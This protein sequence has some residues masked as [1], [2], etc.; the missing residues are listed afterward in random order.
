MVEPI[1]LDL[2]FELLDQNPRLIFGVLKNL[3]ISYQHP[4]YD[5]SL[6]VA[7]E[8]FVKSALRYQKPLEKAAQDPQFGSYA[9]TTVRFAVLR[10]LKK[11][12]RHSETQLNMLDD[13]NEE[14]SRYEVADP[15][16]LQKMYEVEWFQSLAKYLNER[17]WEVLNA[18]YTYQTVKDAAEALGCSRRTILRHRQSIAA[19]LSPIQF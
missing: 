12:R 13:P 1:R 2:A 15:N 16:P 18:L 17:E 11:Q 19:K 3:Q 5:D 8:S 4:L 6:Q 9:F 14:T 10:E 7:R